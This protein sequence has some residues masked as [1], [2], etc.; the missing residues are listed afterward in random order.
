MR[1]PRP[2]IHILDHDEP[3][4]TFRNLTCRCGITLLNAEVKFMVESDV[5]DCMLSPIG[6][7]TTCLDAKPEGEEKRRYEYG[8]VEAQEARNVSREEMAVA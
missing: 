1:Q 3:L 2:K 5:A 8:L 6:S 7:C 4:F